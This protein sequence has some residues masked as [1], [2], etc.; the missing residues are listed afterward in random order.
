MIQAMRPFIDW[1]REAGRLWD[2]FWFTAS[3]THTLC[4][5]RVLA[6]SML[7]YTH[8]IWAV[9]SRDFFGPDAWMQSQVVQRLQAGSA[10]WSYLFYL[11][12]PTALTL[13]HGVALI[14]F[15]MLTIGLWTRVTSVLACVITL[16]YCH[17][18]S[19][20]LYGLDQV[21]A[22][23]A[24]YLLVGPSGQR[25]SLDAWLARRR[26]GA[27]FKQG[28]S[29]SANVAIRLIQV[30]LCVIYLFGGIG[31][32]RGDMWWNGS[33]FW[34]AISNLE[35]QS[36]DVTW[37]I[38]WPALIAFLTNLTM[39]WEV[40]YCALIWP[41]ITR[42]ITLGLA[43]CVH[44]G[45]AVA[46]GMITFGL[47]MIFANLS[48]VSPATTQRIVARLTQWWPKGQGRGQGDSEHVPSGQ[49]GS[50]QGASRKSSKGVAQEPAKQ[51]LRERS[52][53]DRPQQKPRQRPANQSPQGSSDVSH[54]R[55]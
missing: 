13:A 4:A 1:F 35:Y 48:F 39:L 14:V 40:F 53:T 15:A 9:N 6:G 38:Q 5:I 20:S 21:N 8:L 30:H 24:M 37:L 26:E 2:R 47:A 34:Y 50:V 33:A 43:F 32:V 22:M 54:S 41:R 55:V 51:P 18:L 11:E 12:S 28:P 31:K 45:I 52:G 42:P 7:F 25:Y 17:R 46:M 16:A 29:K 10:A 3:E 27:D 36:L 44:A 23:L 49:P 19:G